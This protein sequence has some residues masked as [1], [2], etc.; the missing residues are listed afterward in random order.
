MSK[1]LPVALQLYTVRDY[2][3][4]DFGSTLKKVKEMGYDYV[5]T[6]GLYGLAPSVIS[7][8]LSNAGLAAISAHVPIDELIADTKGTVNRYKT[9]GC[10]YI[11]I[12]YL[13]SGMRPGDEKF[14]DI[15][16][17]IGEIGRVCSAEG[18]TLLYHNH[19]FEF[20]VMPDGSFGLDYI[21]SKIPADL[22]QTELDTCWVKV[23]GQDPASYIR[24]YK[25][26]APVVHL[27]DFRGSKS[28]N[29]YELIGTN[30][31]KA[32]Q[33]AN[34]SSVCRATGSRI[35]LLSLQRRLKPAPNML[36]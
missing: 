15:L 36:L 21:Y 34:S 30:E 3:G 4:K 17:N 2:A 33:A 26:R 18:I 14:D 6:A 22:L 20:I 29:V 10:K 28:E 19:D 35:S 32:E 9:I 11:A 7:E 12:P 13:G 8:E 1:T 31:K 5:E 16:K 24:K 25:G 23:A 27:K